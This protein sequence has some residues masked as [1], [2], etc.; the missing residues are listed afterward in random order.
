[1]SFP[2]Y[3]IFIII[4]LIFVA[5]TLYITRGQFRET[6]SHVRFQLLVF[7][8]AFFFFFT[9][10]AVIENLLDRNAGHVQVVT[11]SPF[12]YMAR[13]YAASAFYFVYLAH[14][15]FLPKRF[16]PRTIL[17]ARIVIASG[18]AFLTGSLILP[19]LDSAPL[20]QTASQLV[21]LSH[22]AVFLST[23]ALEFISLALTLWVLQQLRASEGA[24]PARLRLTFGMTAVVVGLLLNYLT[25][26]DYL[27]SRVNAGHTF[28]VDFIAYIRLCGALMVVLTFM[29]GL[30]LKRIA[31][32]YLWLSS[33]ANVIQLAFLLR[34]FW[35]Y[36][37]PLPWGL[38]PLSHWI[39]HPEFA[40]RWYVVD[41][42]DRQNLVALRKL[43]PRTVFEQTL[44]EFTDPKSSGSEEMF[45]VR[46]A[47]LIALLKLY[48]YIGPAQWKKA[49][50]S[51]GDPH[52][53]DKF[54][55]LH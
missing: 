10:S 24:L 22:E 40:C 42:L 41:I 18:I 21:N 28:S 51:P 3:A 34:Q 45:L 38:P 55:A 23:F 32:F 9:T 2:A 50:S 54:Q 17:L 30:V 53:V 31:R 1:M 47:R 44:F 8:N 25:L 20:S 6:R 33:L 4:P 15:T 48:S 19:S 49:I 43:K 27:V 46:K 13:L 36:T 52:S 14:H 16:P 39:L 26:L 7:Y 37:P 11:D 35:Q 29:P 5:I 12:Y